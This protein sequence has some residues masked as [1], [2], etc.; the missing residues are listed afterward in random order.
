M[1]KP[2]PYKLICPKCKY[3]KTVNPKSDMLDARDI[4]QICPKCDTP[5]ERAEPS[6][7]EGFLGKLFGG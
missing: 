2:Q 5:M 3:R 4:W 7:K 1:I 6:E